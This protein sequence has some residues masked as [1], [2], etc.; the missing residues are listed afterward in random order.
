M[1]ATV[2]ITTS[3]PNSPLPA[4][5]HA[6]RPAM[7][8]TRVRSKKP[9]NEGSWVW[10]SRHMLE[11]I[12]DI[13]SESNQAASVRSI[14]LALMQL[15]RCGAGVVETTRAELCAL[16]GV[17][18]TTLDTGIN[19][20]KRS[21]AVESERIRHRG[22]DTG[23]RVTLLSVPDK[24]A[25]VPA[26]GGAPVPAADADKSVEG[27]KN[28]RIE[29]TKEGVRLPAAAVPSLILNGIEGPTSNTSKRKAASALAPNLETDPATDP[30]QTVQA[31]A[32]YAVY[33]RKAGRG[34]ALKA[35]AKALKKQPADRLLA[36]VHAY[37]QAVA[38]WPEGE[39]QFIPHPATWFNGERYADDPATWVRSNTAKNQPRPISTDMTHEQLSERH[40]GSF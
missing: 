9:S 20:L 8:E 31:E 19:T 10:A 35:I 38:T 14:Y 26:D 1:H 27:I 13:A 22:L 4:R 23:L 33:P 7:P 2:T 3:T 15:D 18:Y 32:I 6:A 12:T 11:A 34:D 24:R 25:P 21:G 16:A 39:R 40:G 36:A 29:V 28:S 37:A 30:T 5:K 17:R